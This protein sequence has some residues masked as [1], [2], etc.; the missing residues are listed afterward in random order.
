MSHDTDIRQQ[1]YQYFAQEAPELLQALEQDL[2]SLAEER[3]IVKVHNLMRTTHTLKGA[4]ANVGLETIKTIAHHLEDVF[5]ALYNPDVVIDAELEAL[6]L[7]GYE[8]LRL[9]LIAEITGGYVN[10]DEVTERA[11]SVFAQL[12]EK[13]GDYF[14]S[15]TPIPTS[16]ELGFDITQSIFEVGVKQ[17]LESLAE[18]LLTNSDPTQVAST[19]RE[20]A[21]IFVGLAE[22]LNLPGFGAIASRTLAALDAHPLDAHR[23]LEVA[24]KDFQ[25]GWDAV[26]SGDRSRGGEPSLELQQLATTLEEFQIPDTSECFHPL[27][28]SSLD[29]VELEIIETEN[30]QDGCEL[31]ENNIF[32]ANE[33]VV[34]DDEPWEIED[35]FTQNDKEYEILNSEFSGFLD[36]SEVVIEIETEDFPEST[37]EPNDESAEIEIEEILIDSTKWEIDNEELS[38]CADE[39]KAAVEPENTENLDLSKSTFSP[40][41]NEV[42]GNFIE[43]DERLN[44][45]T[46]FAPELPNENK[47]YNSNAPL[48][49]TGLSNAISS[50]K[51][52]PSPVPNS[53]PKVKTP[54]SIVRVDLE[55]LERLSYIGGELLINHNRQTNINEQLQAAIAQLRWRHK[56][57]QQT[58]GQLRDW[59]D[60]LLSIQ[61]NKTKENFPNYQ[62]PITNYPS[63]ITN[64][65]DSLELD[66][67]SELH[68]LLQSVLEEMVQLEEA[69]DSIE[70]LTT[71]SSQ[72]LEKQ[73]RLLNTVQE[74][75]QEA[76]MSPLGD[77]FHRFSRLLQQLSISHKKPVDLT[78]LGTD[79]LVDRSLTEKLYDPLL[80]LVRNAF[81]H[82]IEPAE[83][84]DQRGKELTG[85]IEIRAYHQ[86]NQ[87]IIEVRDDGG[88]I[89]LNR[90]RQRA[91]ELHWM[92]EEQAS[93]LSETEILDL[94]FQP[95][96]S[97][98]SKLSDLS[99]RGVGLD[100]VR[101]Q[102]QALSGTVIV[103]SQPQKGTT[104]LLQFPLSLTMAKL[105]IC[106]AG[107]A[108]YA[109]LSDA[110]EQILIPKSDQIQHNNGQRVLHL[111]QGGIQ[112][113]VPAY[114]MT[115][116]LGITS[117][118]QPNYNNGQPKNPMLLL[119]QPS[120]TG[121]WEGSRLVGL[122]IDQILGEQELVI[123]PLGKAIAPKSYVYG[124]STLA[125]GRLTLVIDSTALVNHWLN[126]INGKLQVSDLKYQIETK[127]YL[128]N[129]QSEISNLQLKQLPPA[130]VVLVVDDSIS[131][132]QTLALTLQ[133]AGYKVLQ[134]QNGR[135]AIQ[136]LQHHREI[137][138]VVCDI[139][140]PSMN[141]FEFLSYC[142]QDGELAKL[143]IIMLTSRTAEK[144]R[145]LACELGALGYFNKPFREE[146]ILRA[147]AALIDQN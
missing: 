104:F 120:E 114:T 102:M 78:L 137:R 97:T 69:T 84:R 107:G 86:G 121:L 30:H 38:N 18:V 28:T 39:S 68:L 5:K 2:F 132:R 109:L 19:L 61:T 66:R 71:Q 4:A 56:R 136:Q 93:N 95:G 34:I 16:V 48:I 89:D 74:D 50:L 64:N 15:E 77:I 52:H 88:G 100:V 124:G 24:L 129:L 43:K 21:E 14:D 53:P 112:S 127:N 17:R 83:I 139:E 1:A 113:I 35:D 115:E 32:Q 99:G 9:P 70:L 80:H 103:R 82:G 94:I 26:I 46:E 85:Q 6:L 7:Q 60:R 22:S 126:Q 45:K 72:I 111:N 42:F 29:L 123:R 108:V 138:L 122:E 37:L 117:K 58:I 8:C 145:R 23:V 73:R 55:L 47:D 3:S 25:A 11:V 59:S 146:E 57:H 101:T 144:H 81:D 79:V 49:S 143:P 41:L 76:R 128:L 54:R 51:L 65:F 110:I 33:S 44:S 63:P 62:L 141:G 142:R 98:A 135:E 96:F 119:R 31:A 36:E 12:Q 13:L 75:M 125:D 130:K 118:E 92:S 147:I 131:V 40:S 134:A 10:N 140:M 106:E 91:V 116:L 133:K 67:Y 90:V 27:E 20:Q 105:M 87:T